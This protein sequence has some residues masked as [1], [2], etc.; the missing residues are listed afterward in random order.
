MMYKLIYMK[1]DYEPWWQFEGWEDHIVSCESF[2][3]EEQLKIALHKML[4]E[5][6]L[7]YENEQLKKE[8][9]YAFWSEDESEYCESCDED[10]QI[11]HGVIAVRTSAVSN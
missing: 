7:R 2:E 8:D 6:R 3:T 4:S 1:A 11:Y 5:F 9:Y 10:T